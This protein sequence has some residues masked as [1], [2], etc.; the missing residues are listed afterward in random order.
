MIQY[1]D[2]TERSH[3]EYETLVRVDDFFALRA[4]DKP[5]EQ[6]FQHKNAPKLISKLI[7]QLVRRVRIVQDL[8]VLI[9]PCWKD[10]C[11]STV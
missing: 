1:K 8:N 6:K 11:F 3:R 10:A 7:W 9:R 4:R 2:K 5:R